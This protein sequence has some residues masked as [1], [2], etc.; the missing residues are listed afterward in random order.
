MSIEDR[1]ATEQ[2]LINTGAAG[3]REA[4]DRLLVL[5]ERTRDAKLAEELD[6][7]ANVKNNAWARRVR[8]I[9]NLRT[10]LG[11]ER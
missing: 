9:Q 4:F 6:D 5:V 10:E 8:A 1:S 7:L 2:L 3:D 11:E